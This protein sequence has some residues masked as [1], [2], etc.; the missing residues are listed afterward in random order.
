VQVVRE[1]DR[2]SVVE[3]IGDAG[4]IA[5]ELDARSVGTGSDVTG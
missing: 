3:K 5:A 1:F 4:E 2:Y